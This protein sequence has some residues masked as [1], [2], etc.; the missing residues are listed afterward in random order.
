MLRD[1]NENVVFR[2]LFHLSLNY[3]LLRQFTTDAVQTSLRVKRISLESFITWIVLNMVS[4][5]LLRHIL[6]VVSG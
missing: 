2:P 4:S 6:A 3:V 1:K 5:E